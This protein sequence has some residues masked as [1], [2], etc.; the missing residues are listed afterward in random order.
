MIGPLSA[1]AIV[2]RIDSEPGQAK[3]ILGEDLDVE[4]QMSLGDEQCAPVWAE[5]H[6]GR[7]R[8]VHQIHERLGRLL[9]AQLSSIGRS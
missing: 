6:R 1:G 8:R 4:E 7:G 3:F 5:G 2:L 9:I